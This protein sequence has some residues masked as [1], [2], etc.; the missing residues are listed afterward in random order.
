MARRDTRRRRQK[1]QRKAQ[2]LTAWAQKTRAELFSPEGFAERKAEQ[3]FHLLGVMGFAGS[4]RRSGR[5]GAALEDY[6]DA[7]REA[8]RM[9]F[10]AER[11][12][13]GDKLVMVSGATNLG[14]LELAY[15]LCADLTIW[16]AGVTPDRTLL[17]EVGEMD[18]LVPWGQRFGDESDVFVELCD[19]F[20]LLGGG[21]QSE[22]ETLAA[23]ARGRPV[24]IIQGFGG[25]A[26]G[27]SAELLPNARF[28]QR[29]DTVRP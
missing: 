8:L 12:R 24:T 4:W 15:A 6:K 10:V 2:D 9:H 18:F 23:H 21:P 28:V 7:M 1:K 11:E 20:L 26:D 5:K 25:A 22:R 29:D 14:V 19:S 16:A 13:H 27:L 3:G 17:Y